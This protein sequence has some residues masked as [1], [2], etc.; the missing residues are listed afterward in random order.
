MKTFLVIGNACGGTSITA[1]MLDCLGVKI[2]HSG[3][4]NEQNPKGSFELEEFN[5]ITTK[6]YQ[7]FING[8]NEQRLFSKYQNE[9][10]K[11][12]ENHQSENWGLK[13]NLCHV[14]LS[15]WE[16][17]FNNLHIVVVLR[18]AFENA[19]SWQN[20]L[21]KYYNKK[22]TLEYAIRNLNSQ[23]NTLINNVLKSK[24][25]IFWTSYEKIKFR[26]LEDAKRMSKFS[27]IELNE[28]KIKKILDLIDPNQ[29]TIY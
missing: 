22:V 14:N 25:P 12:I 2:A 9:I 18:N 21:Q 17:H 28:E 26:P 29:S 6:V 3:I 8:K 19:V 15:F 7:D 20:H 1:G 10:I 23:T 27:G 5:K 13:G 24:K 4:Q 16:K 11:I